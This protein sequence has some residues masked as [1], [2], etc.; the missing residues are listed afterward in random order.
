MPHLLRGKSSDTEERNAGN[1]SSSI[2]K[3]YS[4]FPLLASERLVGKAEPIMNIFQRIYTTSSSGSCIL[5][6]HLASL[7][8]A[9]LQ[10]IYRIASRRHLISCSMLFCLRR[11]PLPSRMHTTCAFCRVVA[12]Q[13]DALQSMDE[14]EL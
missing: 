6:N 13:R 5:C 10:C 12:A 8:T 3:N 4:V 1:E 14:V 9:S 11:L 7:A 2:S